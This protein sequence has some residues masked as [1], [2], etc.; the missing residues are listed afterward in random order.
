MSTRPAE[1]E[2]LLRELDEALIA[3]HADMT[4]FFRT[5]SRRVPEI[6]AGADGGGQ[7]F[8]AVIDASAYADL[9]GDFGKLREW[10]PQ[11]VQRL[12]CEER[13]AGEI[14]RGMLRANPKYVL[15][16]YLAQIAIEAA[17]GGDLAPLHRLMHV[18]RHPYDEQPGH[19]NLAAKRPDW[20]RNKPGCSTLSCSS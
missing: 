5:L 1:D 7:A 15:R 8:Q 14:S 12:R 3:S 13:P 18:L 2:S 9:A 6:L 19:D 16:N 4:L 20:A 17:D 11:Y 10:L